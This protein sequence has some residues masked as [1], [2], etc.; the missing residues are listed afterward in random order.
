MKKNYVLDTNVY[1]TD[2]NAIYSFEDND[3]FVPLK[4]LDEIDKHKKRQD[5]V[6]H[7]ARQTIR[8]LDELR[9]QGTLQAG[10]S[11]GE[12]RGTLKVMDFDA[13]CM[14]ENLN[15]DDPD[16]HIIATAITLDKFSETS[17][18]LVSRDINMRVKC[19]SLGLNTQDF[20]INHAVE[21]LDH[22][23]TGFREYVVHDEVVENFYQGKDVYLSQ[24]EIALNPNEFVMLISEVDENKTA[25]CK[26]INYMKPVRKVV[27]HKK[28]WGLE[29]RNKEQKFALDLLMDPEINLV[30]LVGKAGTGKTLTAIAAGLEQIMSQNPTYNK[31]IVSRPV[32]AM[33]KDIGFLPG[34]MEEKM[35]PWLAPIQDN[36]ENLLGGN[37][38]HLSMYMDQGIIEIEA[39]TFIRGRSIANA[40]II[41]DESQNL[42][43]HELKTI[44]TRVGENTKI[45]LTGDIEQIDNAYVDETSN[46]LTHAVERLKSHDITG[47]IMF[48]KGE[49]SKL[50]TIAAKEL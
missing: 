32:Q 21:S 33:G 34:T 49:R 16:N 48:K 7:N 2:F 25:L 40:F 20:Q 27:K 29:P 46:G 4:V 8:I 41:I 36:L 47:H 15:K 50:A 31:L 43:K 18:Y 37:K 42:T 30:T 9:E 11:L 44:I 23:Y 13:A 14:P 17:V 1:L 26:F 39:L 22:V 24:D 10:V 6:G 45:I 35:L 19:D 3:I 5:S 12:G 38:E 28:I